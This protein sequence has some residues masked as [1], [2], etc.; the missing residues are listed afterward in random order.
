M[1]SDIIPQ[2]LSIEHNL[3]WTSKH[4][5]NVWLNYWTRAKR[6]E[7]EREREREEREREREREMERER[8]R[9]E[10][11]RERERDR[12]GERERERERETR[13]RETERER[14]RGQRQRQKVKRTNADIWMKLSDQTVQIQTERLRERRLQGEHRKAMKTAHGYRPNWDTITA[15]GR[16][17]DKR[18][19]KWKRD[20][21]SVMERQ[22]IIRMT[23]ESNKTTRETSTKP[24]QLQER[25][26]ER[27]RRLERQETL[28]SVSQREREKGE[29]NESTYKRWRL[30]LQKT[31]HGKERQ[32]DQEEGVWFPERWSFEEKERKWALERQKREK[33]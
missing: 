4:P 30:V 14:D 32:R 5:F 27:E 10:R 29:L 12:V 20:A 15:G 6:A 23:R 7:R 1:V 2:M 21:F 31:N 19:R 22:K 25:E 3:Y 13:E 16:K 28:Q 18:Q 24:A 11:E 33:E 26:R 9:W 8:E 17:R